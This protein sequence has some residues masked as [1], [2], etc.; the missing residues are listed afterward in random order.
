MVKLDDRWLKLRDTLVF[1]GLLQCGDRWLSF[2]ST[3]VQSGEKC[4]QI[5]SHRLETDNQRGEIILKKDSLV[6]GLQ[7]SRSHLVSWTFKNI[8]GS[9]KAED[10][11]HGSVRPEIL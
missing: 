9:S 6:K 5:I 8:R 4:K 2:G 11:L 1:P 10:T 3:S 7:G